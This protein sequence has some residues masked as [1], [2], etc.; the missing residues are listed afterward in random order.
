M[1]N[2]S[3]QMTIQSSRCPN[4]GIPVALRLGSK[5]GSQ[6]ECPRRADG[7]GCLTRLVLVGDPTSDGWY[8]EL[9]EDAE[10]S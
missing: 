6:R 8:W 3:V 2:C 9:A 4:C 5:E 7:N 10:E 1:G